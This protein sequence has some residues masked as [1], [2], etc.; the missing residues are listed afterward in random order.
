MQCVNNTSDLLSCLGNGNT[1]CVRTLPR[2]WFAVQFCF[3][4]SDRFFL[5]FDWDCLM[6]CTISHRV[7]LSIE[8]SSPPIV[9]Y[10]LLF[11]G[12]MS[13]MSALLAYL[14]IN[15]RRINDRIRLSSLSTMFMQNAYKRAHLESIYDA[16]HQNTYRAA[17][18]LHVKTIFVCFCDEQRL[19]KCNTH[20]IIFLKVTHAQ[21]GL[22]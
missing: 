18:L 14:A 22:L 21:K 11:W 17:G 12:Q 10:S 7:K 5:R 16:M 1:K 6:A 3:W 9:Q 4:F 15:K 20:C 2:H 13:L 19:R 8:A